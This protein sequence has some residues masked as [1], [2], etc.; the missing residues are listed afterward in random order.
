MYNAKSDVTKSEGWE[1]LELL[2]RLE[3]CQR[4]KTQVE[5]L[6]NDWALYRKIVIIAQATEKGEEHDTDRRGV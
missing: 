6:K 4:L 5:I 2:A 3:R 1:V